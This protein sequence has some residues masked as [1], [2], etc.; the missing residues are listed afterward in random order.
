M[1][2]LIIRTI[3][4]IIIALIGLFTITVGWISDFRLFTIAAGV[5]IIIAGIFILTGKIK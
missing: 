2:K 3:M 5:P 1:Q 4:G